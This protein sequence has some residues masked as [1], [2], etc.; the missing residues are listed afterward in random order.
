MCFVGYLC[1]IL[2]L[3]DVDYFVRLVWDDLVR[4]GVVVLREYDLGYEVL[5]GVEL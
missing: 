3:I 2:W 1:C 5:S 4:V